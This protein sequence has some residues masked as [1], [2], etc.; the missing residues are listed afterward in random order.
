MLPVH[1]GFI[2]YFA[3]HVWSSIHFGYYQSRSDPNRAG[4]LSVL[5]VLVT[6]FGVADA[7][8]A[9]FGVWRN[10]WLDRREK[11][12]YSQVEVDARRQRT[13]VE[14]VATKHIH[15]K[16]DFLQLHPANTV[17]LVWTQVCIDIQ[18][19]VG[20]TLLLLALILEASVSEVR[21]LVVVVLMVL[22]AAFTQHLSNVVRGLQDMVLRGEEKLNNNKQRVTGPVFLFLNEGDACRLYLV[23]AFL[24]IAVYL[25]VS[26]RESQT[27]PAM[28][29]FV[30]TVLFFGAASTGFDLVRE[31]ETKVTKTMWISK[32][33]TDKTRNYV[34][35]FMLLMLSVQSASTRYEY[36]DI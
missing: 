7:I 24:F 14:W 12:E 2:L 29:I 9:V 18:Y 13:L 31:V 35:F 27:D 4:V 26:P 8:Y 5:V 30:L 17:E 32:H 21:S 16:H 15:L 20:F 25:I 34:M 19:I 6:A 11:Q 28:S 3:A 36:F 33:D 23:L 22:V 10:S 1:L